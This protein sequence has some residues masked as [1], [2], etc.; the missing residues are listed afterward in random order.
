[1]ANN[2]FE[3]PKVGVQ[4]RRLSDGKLFPAS[5]QN[6]KKSGFVVVYPDGSQEAPSAPANKLE[7]LG[8]LNPGGNATA[9]TAILEQFAQ[10]TNEELIAYLAEKCGV[11]APV[12][13]DRTQLLQMITIFPAKDG[14]PTTPPAA[15][16]TAPKVEGE[17]DPIA[18]LTKAQLV[19]LASTKYGYNL[20]N[21]LNKQ[22]MIDQI[23]LLEGTK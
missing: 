3:R 22:Q 14:T 9:P 21:D 8:I 5:H 18:A 16:D 2:N 12:D 17:T 20:S 7:D 13:S 11:N 19:E 23:R 4:V 1:M 10:A 6:M 15:S